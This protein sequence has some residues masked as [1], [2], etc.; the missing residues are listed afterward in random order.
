[1]RDDIL[2]YFDA[3]LTIKQVL[4]IFYYIYFNDIQSKLIYFIKAKNQNIMDKN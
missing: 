3:I 2:L 4:N 1:M